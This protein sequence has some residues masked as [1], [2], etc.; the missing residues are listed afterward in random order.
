VPLIGQEIPTL[1]EHNF[2]KGFLHFVDIYSDNIFTEMI[3][4]KRNAIVAS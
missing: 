1:P 3:V 2:M 4:F